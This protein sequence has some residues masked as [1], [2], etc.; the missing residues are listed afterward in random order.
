MKKKADSALKVV[1]ALAKAGIRHPAKFW[2]Y[3]VGEP[4]Y[5]PDEGECSNLIF[6]ARAYLKRRKP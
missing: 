4:R 6:R 2:L 3:P 5:R 1:K